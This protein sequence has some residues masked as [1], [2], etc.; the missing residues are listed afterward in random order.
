MAVKARHATPKRRVPS[1]DRSKQRVERILDAAMHVFGE[2]GFDAATMDAIAERAG[3]SIGS[4]YQFFPN[5]KAVFEAMGTRYLDEV[6][7]LFDTFMTEERLARPWQEVLDDGID[8]F[9]AFHTASPG[10]RAVWTS[11]LMSPE[12]MAAGDALNREFA[13]RVEAV[14]SRQSSLSKKRREL[15]AILVVETISSMLIV[16]ARYGEPLASNLMT[17]TKVLIRRYVEPY[18]DRLE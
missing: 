13:R 14:I 10:F 8:A 16:A 15:V 18:A 7:T 1:Q 6:R 5:K 12:F 4:L 11:W 2:L 17:E 3:T 9:W